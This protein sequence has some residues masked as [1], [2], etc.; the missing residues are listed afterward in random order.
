MLGFDSSEELIACSTDTQY[1][2][3]VDPARGEEFKRLLREQGVVQHFE[4][5]VHRKDGSKIWLWTN[6]QAVREGNTVVRYDGT[7]EDI[8]DRKLL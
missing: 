8:T 7:F 5:Q 3:Y 4:L 2:L 1:Q 6:A